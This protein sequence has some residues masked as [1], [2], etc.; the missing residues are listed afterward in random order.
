MKQMML[1]QLDSGDIPE[2]GDWVEKTCQQAGMDK[3][4]AF[5][6]KTCVVE[7]MNN[8]IKHSY[9]GSQGNVSLCVWQQDGHIHVQISDEGKPLDLS[10]LPPQGSDAPDPSSEGGRG[11]MIMRA[12][13]DTLAIT[14]EQNTNVLHLSKRISK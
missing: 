3:I 4:G 13:M 11:L 14:R 7:A 5:Q 8:C 6:V 1:V 9:E 10:T 2:A 12:W